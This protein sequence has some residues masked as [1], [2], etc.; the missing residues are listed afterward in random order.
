[1][2][3]LALALLSLAT[4]DPAPATRPADQPAGVQDKGAQ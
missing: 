2:T 4:Q 3:A 1:M